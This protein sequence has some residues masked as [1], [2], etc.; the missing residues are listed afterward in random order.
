[1]TYLIEHNKMRLSIL[2]DPECT[3]NC[4]NGGSCDNSTGTGECNCRDGYRGSFCEIGR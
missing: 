2:D 4:L 3:L 1:M